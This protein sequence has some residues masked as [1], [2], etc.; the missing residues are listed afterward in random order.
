MKIL[1]S[2][3]TRFVGRHF[4][5]AALSAGHQV[6]LLHRGPV[7]GHDCP[8]PDAEHIHADR[9]ADLSA[10]TGLQFDATFDA[11]AYY[12][13]QVTAFARAIGDGAGL[14]AHISSIS[15]YKEPD[16]PLI[17]ESWPLDE[18]TSPEDRSYGPMKAECERASVAAFAE[19]TMIIRPSYVIGPDDYTWRMPE[20]VRRIAAG[21]QVLCP[22]PADAP[23]Q[24]VD[25]RDLGAFSLQLIE[26]GMTGAVHTAA[27][28]PPFSFGDLLETI[29]SVV[30]PA[31]TELVWVDEDWIGAHAA[32]V[33]LPF[34]GDGRA[35]ILA[36]D[37]SYA[38]SLGLQPRPLTES[39]A[40]TWTW[41]RA[42]TPNEK[43]LLSSAA[44]ADLIARYRSR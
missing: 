17:T 18:P 31:G 16:R 37:P 32:D 12:P 11:N 21:G 25:A 22:G 2:G 14:Y 35:E 36:V 6:T 1:A 20:W 41:L 23:F 4:V 43:L 29:A 9:D 34:A 30:A 13:E 28:M 8:F 10:L 44:Q 42:A 39:V 3:G 7:A 15:A 19:Q 24:Y 33:P 5:A 40:D 27:P 26:Q 38:L